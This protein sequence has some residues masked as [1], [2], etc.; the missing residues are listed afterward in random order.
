MTR[1]IQTP[2]RGLRA[3]LVAAGF[4]MAPLAQANWC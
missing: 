2:G 4:V 1:N 3:A